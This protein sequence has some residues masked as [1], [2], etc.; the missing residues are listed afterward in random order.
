MTCP[1]CGYMMGDLD[2]ACLRC[3]AKEKSSRNP[4][5]AF[6]N[7]HHP[8]A[9]SFDVQPDIPLDSHRED[10]SIPLLSISPKTFPVKASSTKASRIFWIG[11]C[12]AFLMVM[13]YHIAVVSLLENHLSD[14]SAQMEMLKAK[15]DDQ[16]R[17]INDLRD[18]V[19]YNANAAN[20]GRF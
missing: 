20:M 7:E 5:V 10:A 1:D 3:A 11:F 6:Q 19:N 4:Y 12:A 13:I 15:S 17:Q 2:K 9:E 16:Q 8:P 18:T 14:V